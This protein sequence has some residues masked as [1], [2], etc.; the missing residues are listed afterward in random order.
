M[1]IYI[2]IEFIYEPAW[3]SGKTTITFSRDKNSH[4]LLSI[5]SFKFIKFVVIPMMN[6]VRYFGLL[7]IHQL[8]R[9]C[10][11]EW[12]SLSLKSFV[13]VAQ[14]SGSRMSFDFWDLTESPF[15]LIVSISASGSGISSSNPFIRKPF[16]GSL[17]L[18]QFPK[19]QE[20][21]PFLKSLYKPSEELPSCPYGLGV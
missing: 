5:L 16:F 12:S 1:F 17:V 2:L 7:E 10:W 9:F 8:F 18:H 14:I 20:N 11:I 6:N 3:K 13:D 15:G 4:Q 19:N 21:T